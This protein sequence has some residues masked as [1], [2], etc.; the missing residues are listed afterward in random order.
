MNRKELEHKMAVLLGGR[1]AES[2]VFDQVSTGAADDLAKV[3]E[4]ARSMVTRYGMA[5]TLGQVSYEDE[6][7]RFLGVPAGMMGSERRYSEET[8]RMIDVSVRGLV[9]GA[10]EQAVKKVRQSRAALDRAAEVLLAKETLDGAELA[11]LFAES[12]PEMPIGPDAARPASPR[13]ARA[14]PAVG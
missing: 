3:T 13:P 7:N 8:A 6:P 12:I 11:R 10:F 1:A 2:V 4:I 5:D 9:D 14:E